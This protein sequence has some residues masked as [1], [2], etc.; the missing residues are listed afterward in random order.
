MAYQRFKMS[1][2]SDERLHSGRK[3]LEKEAK[4]KTIV[5]LPLENAKKEYGDDLR[6]KPK[7]S[8]TAHLESRGSQW[9]V[10][11]EWHNE[12]P[13]LGTFSVR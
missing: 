8:E 10:P 13:R 3:I 5:E 11:P 1:P 2:L 6:M 4:E 7:R 12:V 9:L